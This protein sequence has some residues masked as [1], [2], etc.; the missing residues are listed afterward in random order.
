[1]IDMNDFPGDEVMV[2]DLLDA[3]PIVR[4]KINEYLRP[5]VI[6]H[7]DLLYLGCVLYAEGKKTGLRLGG[8][9]GR[10]GC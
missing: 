9:A 2:S 3:E 4:A 8:A 10:L 6:H 1:M 5:G 7:G